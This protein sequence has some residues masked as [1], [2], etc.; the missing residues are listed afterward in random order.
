[1]REVSNRE[2]YF[3]ESGTVCHTAWPVF[4]LGLHLSLGPIENA[5][6]MQ[7]C[8]IVPISK[9]TRNTAIITKE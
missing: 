1:M 3:F 8:A 4:F 2:T 5:S 6:D 9:K 7:N